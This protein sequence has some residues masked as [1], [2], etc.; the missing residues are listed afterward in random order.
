M[1]NQVNKSK[2]LCQG[3][4]SSA[5]QRRTKTTNQQHTCT[6][7]GFP[8]VELLPSLFLESDGP[9]QANGNFCNE[10]VL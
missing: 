8:L 7:F 3:T 4:S 2:T 1:T 5:L 9:V 10:L 6:Y